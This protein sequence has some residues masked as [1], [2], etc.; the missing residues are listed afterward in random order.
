MFI[1]IV[2]FSDEIE[3]GDYYLEGSG[4]MK[5]AVAGVIGFFLIFIESLIVMQFKGMETIEFGG[6]TPFINVWAMNFFLV[7]S[8]LS[9]L[10]NWYENRRDFENNSI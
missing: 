8:I 1:K 5:A 7:F 9:Q 4:M 10:K 6:L 2:K 3:R